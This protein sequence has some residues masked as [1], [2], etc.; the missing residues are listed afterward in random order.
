[1]GVKYKLIYPCIPALPRREAI[2]RR[3]VQEFLQGAVG[4]RGPRAA[5]PQA[6]PQEAGPIATQTRSEGLL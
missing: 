4:A 3:A 6:K 1:M 5:L 2:S